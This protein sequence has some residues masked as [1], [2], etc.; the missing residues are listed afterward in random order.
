MY[1]RSKLAGNKFIDFPAELS[2]AIA[3]ITEG[4]SFAYLKEVFVTS[5][6]VIVGIQRGTS[7]EP[8]LADTETANG[9]AEDE[10]LRTVQSNLLYRVVK[11]NVKILRIEMEGSRKSAEDAA[12]YSAPNG[13]LSPSRE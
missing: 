2:K 10:A 13:A 1:N 9:A 8:E 3:D 12:N 4:F 5:L 7:T 11:K 6:L